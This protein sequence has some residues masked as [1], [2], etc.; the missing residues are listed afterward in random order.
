M[1]KREEKKMFEKYYFEFRTSIFWYI[2]KKVNNEESAQDITT[3]VFMKLLENPDILSN[4]EQNGVRAWLYTVA[5]NAVIDSYRKKSNQLEKTAIDD[6]VF[7]LIA[8][9]KEDHLQSVIKD[10]QYQL[11]LAAMEGL[12]T[13]EKEIVTLRFMDEMKF[14]EIAKIVGKDEGAVKMML[15][16]SLEK[17]QSKIKREDE[18]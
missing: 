3:D 17:I 12:G 1:N 9:D 5:R 15:Y 6:D 7:D 14:N 4:R 10:E 8:S 13:D 16:R 2:R 18:S 11:I